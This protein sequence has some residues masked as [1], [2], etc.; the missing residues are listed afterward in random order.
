MDNSCKEPK[1]LCY[2]LE[3]LTFARFAFGIFKSLIALANIFAMS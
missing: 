1:H 2:S 3:G